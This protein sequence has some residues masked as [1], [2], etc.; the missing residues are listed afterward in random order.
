MAVVLYNTAGREK[1][2][3]EPIDK[4][5]V[6]LYVCGPTVYDFAHI[7]NARPVVVFDVL[8]RLLRR[9]YGETHVTYVRNITDIDDKIIAAAEASGEA[10][11][12][13]TSRTTQAFHRDMAALDALP[14]DAEPRATEHVPQMIA[15]IQSLIS[16]G[17]AYVGEDHVLFHVPSAP[18]Y[19]ALSGRN[20]KEQIAGARVDVAPYKKDPADF[21]LW[22]PSAGELPGWDSPWG[23]GR[24]GWH[25]ECSAMSEAHLGLPFDIHGGGLDLVFPHHENEVAQS[26]CAHADGRFVN[27]WMHNGFVTVDGEK[28]AKS[29]GNI[30]LVRDLLKEFPGEAVRL[31]M[32]GTHYRQPLDWTE[33]GVRQAKRTLDRWYKVT[34]DVTTAEADMPPEFVAALEDDLNTP[35]AITEMHKLAHEATLL[36]AAS[37]G[38]KKRRLKAAGGLLGILSRPTR[39]WFAWQPEGTGIEAE[40]IET[41][42]ERRAE[43]RARRDYAQADRIR[44]ELAAKG[45]ALED[46]P[47]GRTLWRRAG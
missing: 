18:R 17:H 43:A 10:I 16:S 28:M 11:E 38:E 13:I 7:G 14:P 8:Y 34:E 29:V 39:E 42:L 33:Q 27:Y 44:E 32:L 36:G 46:D 19:G 6:R 2:P 47:D 20:R 12:T 21:V 5:N 23:R 9:E 25:V 31:N 37:A 45:I 41:L 40:E 15:L 4:G 30:L 1:Q 22:K 26:T 24:P 35:Q 3:F